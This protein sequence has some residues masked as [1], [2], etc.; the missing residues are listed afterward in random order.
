MYTLYGSEV[1]LFTGKIRAYLRYK[2]L[3]FEEVL[4]TVRVYKKIIRPNTGVMFIPVVKTPDQ[5][6][7]QDTARIVDFIEQNTSDRGIIPSG[8]AQQLVSELFALWGDEWLV[9]PAMHYRWNKKANFPFIYEEF[10]RVVS[11]KLPA[12]VR[13]YFGR[14]LASK[15]KGFVPMLGITNATIPSIEDWYENTVLH[16][17]NLHFAEHDYLLGSRACVGDLGLMGPLY[18]H[19]YRDPAPRELMKTLAPNVVA[20]VERMNRTNVNVGEYISNDVIPTTLM[21][22]LKDMFKQQWPVLMSTA[23][24]LHTWR[25]Q[26]PRAHYIPR[27]IGTHDFYIGDTQEQRYVASF[28]QYKLQRVIES[29]CQ[30]NMTERQNVEKMLSEVGGLEYL[31]TVLH[32]TVTFENNRLVFE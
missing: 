16:H 1:S 23:R 3:P 12:F 19:L 31:Q 30:L 27:S 17:L 21:P 7:L 29:Y 22:L 14:K 24:A 32:E 6:Y 10:G 26:N 20:W 18:A 8:P 9:I 15:F 25:K 11:P 4:S 2:Q 13:R 5:Q 28:H